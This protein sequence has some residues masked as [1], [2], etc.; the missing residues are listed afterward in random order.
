MSC[1]YDSRGLAITG[2]KY[3]FSEIPR[4]TMSLG[5]NGTIVNSTGEWLNSG[6]MF[7]FEQYYAGSVELF[8]RNSTVAKFDRLQEARLDTCERHLKYTN[9]SRHQYYDYWRLA[10]YCVIILIAL[11]ISMLLIGLRRNKKIHDRLFVGLSVV[12]LAG[13]YGILGIILT[14]VGKQFQA[15]EYMYYMAV[16]VL[17]FSNFVRYTAQ[18]IIQEQTMKFYDSMYAEGRLTSKIKANNDMQNF[19]AIVPREYT[20]VIIVWAVLIMICPGIFI[21]YYDMIGIEPFNSFDLSVTIMKFAGPILCVLF[22]AMV[23]FICFRGKFDLLGYRTE[24]ITT[25]ILC[26]PAAVITFTVGL[27]DGVIPNH[28][29]SKK[30]ILITFHALIYIIFDVLFIICISGITSVR[31]AKKV[32]ADDCYSVHSKIN[33]KPTRGQ[34]LLR[35]IMKNDERML[36]EFCKNSGN[37]TYF[38]LLRWISNVPNDTAFEENLKI[39]LGLYGGGDKG[40]YQEYSTINANLGSRSIEAV[41][42]RDI[43]VHMT[44]AYLAESVLRDGLLDTDAYLGFLDIYSAELEVFLK[45]NLGQSVS[46]FD[47]ELDSISFTSSVMQ[48]SSDS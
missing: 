2:N 14:V 42:A 12:F 48:F 27:L 46:M 9:L 39:F 28:L 7:I 17:Y 32:D 6:L 36:G 44:E 15:F 37:Y 5:I 34:L 16:S 19:M 18:K 38:G 29:L 1:F 25:L 35:F 43:A 13:L 33:M 8:H 3:V 10:R 31:P 41:E 45:S 4:Y 23:V 40:L 21:I 26:L 20:N 24:F 30:M 47:I 22:P 11:T